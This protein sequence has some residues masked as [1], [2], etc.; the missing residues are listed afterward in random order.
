MNVLRSYL[1]IMNI[2][3][4]VPTRTKRRVIPSKGRYFNL[5]LG[6]D[7][8]TSLNPI[9]NSL[10]KDLC[11]MMSFISEFPFVLIEI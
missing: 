10:F 8:E 11:S 7:V 4:N 5:P 2:I 3:P 9:W 6:I 1:V